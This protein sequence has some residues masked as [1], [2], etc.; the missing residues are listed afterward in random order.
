M[1]VTRIWQR[2]KSHNLTLVAAGVAFYAMLAIFPALVALVSL[3]GLLADPEQISEQ[4]ESVTSAMPQAA[5]DLLVDQLTKTANSSGGSLTVGLVVSVLFAL[6]SASGGIQALIGG[7][8]V[9]YGRTES[10]GFIRLRAIGFLVTIGAIGT[11][12]LALGLIAAFPFVL[13][14]IGL[15]AGI[16]AHVIRWSV[17]MAMIYLGLSLL[18]YFGPD[19]DSPRWEWFTVG[20]G[21]AMGLWLLSSAAFAVYVGNF[22]NYNETYGA[23][24]AVIILLLWLYLSSFLILLG[25]TI[26]VERN[27]YTKSN[28]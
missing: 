20:S 11:V 15:S 12:I 16:F 22:G 26:N 10:R 27:L 28:K 2:V 13:D 9:V 21:V 18:Y 25:A 23:L 1:L 3:Y 24:S 14:K 8:N 7:L 4:L 19:R 6:W 17:L 5:G